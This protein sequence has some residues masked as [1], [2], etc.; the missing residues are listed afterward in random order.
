MCVSCVCM[1]A[2]AC[3]CERVLTFVSEV[4]EFLAC[5]CLRACVCERV[6]TSSFVSVVSSFVSVQSVC[7]CLLCVHVHMM[8]KCENDAWVCVCFLGV[9]FCVHLVRD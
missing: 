8:P 4:C 6:P 3:A 2:C 1:F 5:K 9:C 7:V